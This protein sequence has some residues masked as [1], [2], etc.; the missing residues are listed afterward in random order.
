VGNLIGSVAFSVSSVAFKVLATRD[1]RSASWTTI[2]TFVGGLCF[3]GAS[4][5]LLPEPT[6][7]RALP[8]TAPTTTGPM[9]PGRSC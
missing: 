7:A 5:L 1:L 9:A 3:L 6:R 2:G 4:I 8:M